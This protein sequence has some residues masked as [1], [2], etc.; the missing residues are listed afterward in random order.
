MKNH[1]LDTK[2]KSF[3]ALPLERLSLLHRDIKTYHEKWDQEKVVEIADLAT[4]E[5]TYTALLHNLSKITSATGAG[6][7]LYG[8]IN[9]DT[10]YKGIGGSITVTALVTDFLV[11]A[12][13]ER[14]YR[15]EERK[16]DRDHRSTGMGT[17]EHPKTHLDTGPKE[18]YR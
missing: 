18:H 2:I 4:I 10:S 5:N 11:S 9:S 17:Y 14:R 13:R 1:E 7:Y 8:E 6:I 15:P 12:Y 16:K 3:S